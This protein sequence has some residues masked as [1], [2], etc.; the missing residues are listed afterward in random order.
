MTRG[1]SVAVT[2][3]VRLFKLSLFQPPIDRIS[4]TGG[5]H[6]HG[7]SR[8]EPRARSRYSL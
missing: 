5:A 3:S 8:G 6:N 7:R 4:P 1:S 2:Q